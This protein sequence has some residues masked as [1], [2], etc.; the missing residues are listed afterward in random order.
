MNLSKNI[1]I[2]KILNYSDEKI[3]Q[4][5]IGNEVAI[6]NDPLINRLLLLKALCVFL[7]LEEKKLLYGNNF[8]NL[9]IENNGD[10]N[11]FRNQIIKNENDYPFSVSTT[12]YPDVYKIEDIDIL[13]SYD[14]N[15][16]YLAAS[17]SEVDII[18]PP[19]KVHQKLLET[20]PS[21]EWEKEN[22]LL[23][24]SISDENKRL[25]NNYV[26]YGYRYMNESLRRNISGEAPLNDIIEITNSLEK[27]II[28]FRYSKPGDYLRSSGIFKSYG[29]LSTSINSY[30]YSSIPDEDIKRE[31]VKM[32]R[33]I[34]RIHV[35][36]GKK[37]IYVPGHE[38][39]LIFPHNIDLEVTDS[40]KREIVTKKKNVISVD[41][42]E[43]KML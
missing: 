5:L 18:L 33:A 17:M 14:L 30:R 37:A 9:F 1:T 6:D 42:Y 8:D 4:E 7:S 40:Y 35:P 12:S 11:R 31:N 10:V 41:F 22:I 3:K 21:F 38:S 13:D 36:K 32:K 28:V 24:S 16:L 34:M 25:L 43:I 23:V 15:E 39:E 26:S 2:E 29:Y 20:L 27:D 19:E